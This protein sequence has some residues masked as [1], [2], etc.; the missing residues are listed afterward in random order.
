MAGGPPSSRPVSPHR[1]DK[2][3]QGE[4]PSPTTP[5]CTLRT[6]L[7]QALRSRSVTRAAHQW[8]CFPM[9]FDWYALFFWWGL[10]V[11]LKASTLFS[12]LVVRFVA[13]GYATHFAAA[14]AV[15]FG[16]AELLLRGVVSCS[17]APCCCQ[18]ICVSVEIERE[19]RGTF[20]SPPL[21]SGRVR[22]FGFR[23]W[24]FD[25]RSHPMVCCVPLCPQM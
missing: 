22:Y 15:R 2:N 6:R 9:T 13:V 7:A 18:T 10:C 19:G 8:C 25:G 17:V 24:R 4:G 21:W 16:S 3:G 20:A 11:R 5:P 23:S 14:V 1:P 12:R